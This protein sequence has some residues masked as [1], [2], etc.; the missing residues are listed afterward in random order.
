MKKIL[1]YT[2]KKTE[3]DKL[4]GQLTEQPFDIISDV[5]SRTIGS[6]I[7]PTPFNKI[8]EKINSILS[9]VT[10]GRVTINGANGLT[11]TLKAKT[12]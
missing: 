1:I 7:E 4:A 10:K 9:K 2:T 5:F 11:K 8:G 3:S 6:E 12:K